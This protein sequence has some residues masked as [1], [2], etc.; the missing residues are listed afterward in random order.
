MSQRVSTFLDA[1]GPVASLLGEGYEPRA[2]QLEMAG[3]VADT[4]AQRRRLLVEA[5]TGVGKSYAYLIPAIER[6]VV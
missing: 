5:G 3:A 2:Q 1:D 6:C 4:L